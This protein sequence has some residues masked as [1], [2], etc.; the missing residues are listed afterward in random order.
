[1]YL[2]FLLALFDALDANDNGKAFYARHGIRAYGIAMTTLEQVF[3]T[4]G[5]NICYFLELTFK[6]LSQIL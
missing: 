3:L 6:K 1:M 4:L 2:E 5:I